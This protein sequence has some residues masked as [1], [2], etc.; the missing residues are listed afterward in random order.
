MWLI[1]FYAGE[2]KKPRT[3]WAETF[4][5]FRLARERTIG[6]Q[7]EQNGPLGNLIRSL[8]PR[9]GTSARA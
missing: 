9:L 3:F 6:A 1:L 2:E 5:S 7:I 8:R 4:A